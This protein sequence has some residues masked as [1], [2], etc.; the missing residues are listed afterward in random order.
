MFQ[1]LDDIEMVLF[2]TLL[3]AD[4]LQV[5]AAVQFLIRKDFFT[6]NEFFT[7]LKQVQAEYQSRVQ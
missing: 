3:M 5:N 4:S 2:E 1:Q 7:N 6:Q